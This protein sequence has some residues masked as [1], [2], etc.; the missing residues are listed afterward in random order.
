ML[1]GNNRGFYTDVFFPYYNL[2]SLPTAVCNSIKKPVTKDMLFDV[3]ERYRWRPTSSSQGPE[4]TQ[5]RQ[6][7]PPPPKLPRR[8]R[9]TWRLVWIIVSKC[10][11]RELLTRRMYQAP[12]NDES[13]AKYHRCYTISSRARTC[14]PNCEPWQWM[15]PGVAVHSWTSVLLRTNAPS[16]T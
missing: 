2:P 16:T 1:S 5:D 12:R 8:W 4:T 3:I 7:M 10:R 11:A 15:S 6:L 9:R 14:Y 13:V